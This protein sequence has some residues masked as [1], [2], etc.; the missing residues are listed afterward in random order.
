M[1]KENRKQRGLIVLCSFG[2]GC[3]VNGSY[4]ANAY[5]GIDNAAVD[6]S[7]IV[8]ITDKKTSAKKK[9]YFEYHSEDAEINWLS[10]SENKTT[11]NV[12]LNIE[13]QD[14]QDYL[15]EGGRFQKDEA[16]NHK[17]FLLQ[18]KGQS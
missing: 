1:G 12:H 17:R 10:D 3:L 9:I 13:H 11:I 15:T 4:T 14:G 7:I 5:H 16:E 18:K 2:V 8:E 6:Y